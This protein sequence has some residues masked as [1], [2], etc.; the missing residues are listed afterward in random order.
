MIDNKKDYIGCS[1]IWYN[2][3]KE[4]PHNPKNIA[5][6]IVVCGLRHANCFPILFEL[7]PDRRYLNSDSQI[8][9]TIQGFLTASGNFVDRDEG[10][11]IA[12]AANQITHNEGDTEILMS[13]DL[14]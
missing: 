8:R 7:F 14:Y 9:T 4:R 12:M 2:D 11:K 10:W 6:G 5:T 1:A 3:S 13:E